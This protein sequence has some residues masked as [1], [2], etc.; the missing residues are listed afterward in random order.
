MKGY[1]VY[2]CIDNVYT[3]QYNKGEVIS[4]PGNTNMSIRIDSELKTQAEQIL[5]QF[6]M[7]MTGA[8]NMFLQQVVRERAV[9]LSLSLDSS[10]AL[11]VDLLSA[12]TDREQGYRGRTA[13]EVLAD[14]RRIIEEDRQQDHV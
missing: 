1:R 3:V 6:G 13:N 14:M 4:M 8:V 5:S 11:Y 9:P 2:S 10:N 12:R 7:N